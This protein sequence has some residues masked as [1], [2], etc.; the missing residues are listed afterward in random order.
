MNARLISPTVVFSAR[1]G[2]QPLH[3]LLIYESTGLVSIAMLWRLP[4]D[5][6]SFLPDLQLHET[7]LPFPALEKSVYTS[8]LS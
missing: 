4:I 6:V 1:W 3:I 2:R 7:S 8:K 5:L